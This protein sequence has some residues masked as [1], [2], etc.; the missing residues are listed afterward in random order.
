MTNEA[1]A[2]EVCEVCEG[3]HATPDWAEDCAFYWRDLY[4]QAI[5]ERDEL[6]A[7]LATAHRE[8]MERA[9]EIAQEHIC[10]TWAECCDCS[11]KITNAIRRAME[12]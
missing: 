9:M 6:K 8:G 3:N 1:K 2:R 12:E 4:R 11:S 5:K 7:Q 10:W